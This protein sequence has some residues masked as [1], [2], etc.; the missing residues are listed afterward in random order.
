VS[1]G[2]PATAPPLGKLAP[3]DLA[4]LITPH[5]GAARPEVVLGPRPGTDAAIVR[6]GAGRVMTITTDPLSLIPALGPAM[7]AR[8]AVH[9][10]ASDL[11]TSGIPPAYAAVDLALPPDL[12]DATLGAYA[13]AMGEEWADLGV[14][15]VTGH[16]GRY[17]GCGLTIVGSCTLIG[18]GDEGRWVGA[19][20]VEPGDRVIVTKDCA[21][22]AT[23]LAAHLFPQRLAAHLEPDA[24][25][26][27]QAMLAE[28]SVVRDC[29]AALR[30][31][32]REQGV[33]AL[34]DATEGGVVGGLVEMARAC[35]HDLRV[36]RARIPLSAEARGACAMMGI[37]PWSALS[38]GTLLATVRPAR[39]DA[40]LE[41]LALEGIEAAEV[42]EV[43]RG[44]GRLWLTEG[45]RDVRTLDEPPADP[46]WDA[47]A[48][49]VREGWA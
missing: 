9:L 16:T 40:V 35:G 1:T 32:A 2:A 39:V 28:V 13:A 48:R 46:W 14:A 27:A 7:S 25:E 42:G 33:S 21:V 34:H 31:G 47:Y 23:A 37:D 11:W 45:D 38:E 12:D 36:D 30:A 49:A 15:V 17:E 43:V 24:I 8:L 3:A 26:R 29:I 5:L 18:I 10:V 4:R 44:S 6:V 41:H 19:P 22:E 20:F